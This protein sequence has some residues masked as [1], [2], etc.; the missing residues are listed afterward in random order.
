MKLGGGGLTLEEEAEEEMLSCSST[1]F[2]S[3]VVFQMMLFLSFF[4][5]LFI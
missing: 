2:L 5:S 4:V 3:F 1:H